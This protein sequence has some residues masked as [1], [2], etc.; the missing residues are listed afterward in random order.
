MGTVHIYTGNGGGKTT[1]ALGVCLRAIGHGKKVLFIQFMKGRM[2]GELLAARKLKGFE[3]KQFGRREF[4][5]LAN[6][7]AKDKELAKKGMELAKKALKDPPYLLVL[8]ELNL[9]ASCGLVGVEDVLE[10]IGSA[11]KRL[12]IIITGRNAPKEL[13]AQADLATEISDLKSRITPI[14]ARKGIEY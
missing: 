8:D 9:A 6:P 4:V 5:D 3:I 12:N 11:P 1:A 10:L 2:T 13:I 7:S 14:K